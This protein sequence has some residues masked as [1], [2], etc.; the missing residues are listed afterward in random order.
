MT[1]IETSTERIWKCRLLLQEQAPRMYKL[2]R[3]PEESYPLKIVLILPLYLLK[4]PEPS[5]TPST[6]VY[7]QLSF[8]FCYDR[9][10]SLGPPFLPIIDIFLLR[11][12][13]AFLIRGLTD[14]GESDTEK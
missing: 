14:M 7:I 1:L 10:F 6:F 5:L 9:I 13:Y 11:L 8:Q 3:I 12:L 2:L 4:F